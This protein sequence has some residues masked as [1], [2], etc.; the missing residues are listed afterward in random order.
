M[1][2]G[3]GSC[4]LCRRVD[5]VPREGPTWDRVVVPSTRVILAACHHGTFMRQGNIPIR[6]HVPLA[7]HQ[8]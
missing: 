6:P 5:S 2:L 7:H 1:Q 8:A 3:F 4:V